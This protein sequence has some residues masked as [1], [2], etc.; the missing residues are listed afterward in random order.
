MYIETL[1]RTWDHYLVYATI[2][3]EEGQIRKKTTE[4]V[5]DGLDGDTASKGSIGVQEEGG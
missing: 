2:G 3:D 4:S 5:A 1:Y